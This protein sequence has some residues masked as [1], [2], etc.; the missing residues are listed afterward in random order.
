[1]DLIIERTD[2]VTVVATLENDDDY[3]A[4]LFQP[5]KLK[6][7]EIKLTEPEWFTKDKALNDIHI[8]QIE[9][10]RI[11]EWCAFS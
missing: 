9:V 10:Y 8:K 11:S 4:G 6:S 7:C 2:D 1:M 5:V 3:S